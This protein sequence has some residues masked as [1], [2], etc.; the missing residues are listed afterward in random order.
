ME[1]I[2]GSMV[3]LSGS[4]EVLVGSMVFLGGSVEVLGGCRGGSRWF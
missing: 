4:M 1:F 2:G 3:F